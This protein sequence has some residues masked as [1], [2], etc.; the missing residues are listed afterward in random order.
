LNAEDWEYIMMTLGLAD[1]YIGD[2]DGQ[3]FGIPESKISENPHKYYL[4]TICGE[5]KDVGDKIFYSRE[6]EALIYSE[7]IFDLLI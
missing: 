3:R 7:V 1:K 6:I 2:I 5:A 4:Y